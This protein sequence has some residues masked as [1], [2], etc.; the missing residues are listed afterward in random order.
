[1]SHNVRVC[2]NRSVAVKLYDFPPNTGLILQTACSFSLLIDYSFID[3]RSLCSPKI[4]NFKTNL[5]SIKWTNTHQWMKFNF[6]HIENHDLFRCMFV[7]ECHL[8]NDI[9]YFMH[10][11]GWPN[12]WSKVKVTS[13]WKLEIFPFSTAISFA[14]CYGSWQLTTDA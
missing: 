2:F 3:L 10:L 9:V 5:L 12:N 8:A 14:I 4:F 13:P 6:W 7:C 11:L 1:M